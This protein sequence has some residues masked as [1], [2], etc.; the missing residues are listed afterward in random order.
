M[1]SPRKPGSGGLVNCPHTRG[2]ALVRHL[3]GL[4]VTQGQ[5]VG[6]PF[7][8]LP[9]Q[10]R[11]CLGA[12]KVAGD[13]ALSVARANG[14]TT[15][16]AG[17]ADAVL[18]GPLRQP[19]AECVVVA[20]SF[21]QARLTFDHVLAFGGEEYLDRRT[22]RVQDTANRA[23]IEHRATG[24]KVRCIGSDPKRMMGLAPLLVLADE[25]SSYDHTKRDAAIA[26]LRTSMG[27]IPG[28]RLIAFGT[29]PSD[30][31]HWFSKMLRGTGADYFQ[32]H[33]ARKADPPFQW[34]TWKRANP[35]LAFMPYLEAKI[36][37][38]AKDAKSD[39]AMMAE[40]V[41][42]RL[43][44]GGDGTL[45]SLLLDA[46]TWERIEVDM[47]ER[48]GPWVLGLDLG[49]NAAMSG[50]AGYWPATG[51][52]DA[53][54]C[55]PAIPGLAERGVADG[56]GRR[57]QD[58]ARRG[59]LIV[60]GQRVSDLGGLLREVAARWGRPSVIVCD[61]WRE[62]ELRQALEAAKFPPAT[63]VVR[64]M[65]F[66]D[67]GEDVRRFRAA[68]L[69]DR[70]RPVRSLL[71]RSAMGEARTVGD[72]AGNWKL[73]KN[74]AGGRRLHARDDAAAAAILAVAEGDRRAAA[75]GPEQRESRLVG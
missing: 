7:T 50:A 41:A 23:S 42:L 35:S 31:S 33:S 9:W 38:A 54:A 43:N 1:A 66:R 20:S 15:L 71:L 46:G 62:A 37:Q 21:D 57:Y 72:P 55:F 30:D 63:L 64:G 24:A 10:R 27:K 18:R 11:F 49:Q 28:S 29:R 58:M 60:A 12:F 56:V 17:I 8:V 6:D 75:E 61:R 5:G 68:C 70:V 47:T 32:D 14:K 51:S 40:F 73:A 67:G 44:G 16:C 74:T 52:L 3:A 69:G 59:E 19:R 34:R 22:W 26:A 53:F 39:P 48:A 2:P 36:R 25:P 65:G 45:R 4:T 13:A